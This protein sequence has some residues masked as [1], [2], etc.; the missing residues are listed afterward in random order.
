MTGKIPQ[1]RDDLRQT[2]SQ[3][4]P[5]RRTWGAIEKRSDG[6]SSLGFNIAWFII[7][8]AKKSPN[9][10]ATLPPL[11]NLS[12]KQC[13]GWVQPCAGKGR[14][15]EGIR[16]KKECIKSYETYFANTLNLNDKCPSMKWVCSP[17]FYGSSAIWPWLRIIPH[18]SFNVTYCLIITAWQWLMSFTYICS[19]FLCK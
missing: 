19:V 3:A 6:P 2:R 4:G 10:L 17:K 18:S 9:L 7:L 12:L 11:L 15:P 16:P 1:G 5:Q 8:S 13:W 14:F